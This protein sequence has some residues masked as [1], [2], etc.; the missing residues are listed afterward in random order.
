VSCRSEPGG[1]KTGDRYIGGG[2]VGEYTVAKGVSR[3]IMGYEEGKGLLTAIVCLCT[4]E[5]GQFLGVVRGNKIEEGRVGK[6]KRVAVKGPCVG[7]LE[8][9]SA[10][11][12]NGR[13][14]KGNPE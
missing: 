4:W 1:E 8:K 7:R 5:S 11:D 10:R 6:E 14:D 3:G 9:I 2:K 12:G 13:E